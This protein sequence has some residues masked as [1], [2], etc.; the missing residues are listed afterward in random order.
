MLHAVC[1]GQ[2]RGGSLVSLSIEN[3]PV[4]IL[5]SQ[6]EKQSGM[7]FSYNASLI[8]SDSIITFNASEIRVEKAISEVFDRRIKA[9]FIGSHIVLIESRQFDKKIAKSSAPVEY[10]F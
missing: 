10:H 8:N 3:Q 2:E 7:S 9:K 4:K 1:F 6:I 5:F